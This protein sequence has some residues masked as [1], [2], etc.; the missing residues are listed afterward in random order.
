MI[1]IALLNFVRVINTKQRAC[2]RG[3]LSE[4]DQEALVDLAL[5]GNV[6]PAEQEH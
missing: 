5:R 6:R 4:A 1:A 3:D 2:K